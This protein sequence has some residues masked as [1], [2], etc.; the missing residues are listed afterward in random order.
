LTN[1]KLTGRI[2]TVSRRRLPCQNSAV[3]VAGR[4][5]A[6]GILFPQHSVPTLPAFFLRWRKSLFQ[7]LFGFYVNSH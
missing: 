3:A 4:G 5:I 1:G 6:L 7:N 2:E